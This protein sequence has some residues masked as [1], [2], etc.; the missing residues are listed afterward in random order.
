MGAAA[1]LGGF[2]REI[3]ALKAMV[4]W[5]DGLCPKAM[6]SGPKLAVL[7]QVPTAPTTQHSHQFFPLTSALMV[8]TIFN[9]LIALR[10][11]TQRQQTVTFGASS[12]AASP[13]RFMRQPSCPCLLADPN[14]GG[15]VD[16]LA[17]ED[18]ADE[19]AFKKGEVYAAVLCEGD[20]LGIAYYDCEDGSLNATST[21]CSATDVPWVIATFKQQLA[22]KE[23]TAFITR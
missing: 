15:F 21:H 22:E 6:L 20:R 3:L 5:A 8:N 11:P 7:A 1:V 18:A 4:E 19:M 14:Y 13:C 10:P 23:P 16:V 9:L 2:L 17:D 12:P